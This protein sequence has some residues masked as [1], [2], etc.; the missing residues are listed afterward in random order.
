MLAIVIPYYK[1]E[2]FR[3][4][5]ESLA[6]QTDQR[7]KVYIGDD[8]SPESPSYLLE[9]YKNH[10]NF[11]YHHFE[12]NLGGISLVKQWERC[13]IMINYEKWLMILGDD[14]V[15]E[16]NCVA[17]FYKNL[18]E[19]EA[20]KISAIR[21][22]TRVINDKGDSISENYSHPKI[23]ST[24]DFLMR[25]LNGGT[26][27]SLSEYI[28]EKEII[29]Q[30]K[31]KDFPLA[32]NSDLLAVLEFSRW[33]NIFTINEAIVCF[34]LSGMNI[35]SKKDNLIIKNNATFQF[36]FYLLQE[37]THKLSKE[38]IDILFD[39]FEK[40]ILD[41]KKHAIYW[42]KLFYLYFKFFQIKRFLSLGFKIKKSIK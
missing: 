30:I 8:A 28:F 24:G 14:D 26:R 2:F 6:N 10:F 29:E 17:S 13:M 23:E 34:R 20:L 42:V 39:R 22:S 12:D 31:F 33:N 35:T 4:T 1:L 40:T 21:F 38:L 3:E 41:N 36:Y 37:Q 32:W 16:N 25:K 11:E 19:I 9:L 27:S 18:E 5:L 15:L 7:F